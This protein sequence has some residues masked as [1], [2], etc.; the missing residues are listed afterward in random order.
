MFVDKEV[1]L[2]REQTNIM[3]SKDY[4]KWIINND[5]QGYFPTDFNKDYGGDWESQAQDFASR[6]V[7]ALQAE[8]SPN[9][10]SAVAMKMHSMKNQYIAN[11]VNSDDQF[12][13]RLLQCVK[14][15]PEKG[16]AIKPGKRLYFKGVIRITEKDGCIF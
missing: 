2:E 15:Y 11:I 4:N 16:I 14:K 1:L 8:Q 5:Q 10:P 7:I 12:N 13:G 6:A 9:I 3:L